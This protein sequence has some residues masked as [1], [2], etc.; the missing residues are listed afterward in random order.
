LPGFP[1]AAAPIDNQSKNAM[2]LLNNNGSTQ[3]ESHQS[4]DRG[5]PDVTNPTDGSEGLIKK[6][7]RP[8]NREQF[9]CF[10]TWQF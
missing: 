8:N 5:Y 10:S 3:S 6:E 4:R 2:V 1:W 7:T 9:A